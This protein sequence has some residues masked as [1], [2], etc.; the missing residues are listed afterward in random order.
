MQAT[1]LRSIWIKLY[2]ACIT[3]R[4][5]IAIIYYSYRYRDPALVRQKADY[6]LAWWSKRL[7]DVIGL[8]YH[9]E[10]ADQLHFTPGKPYIIMCSHCSFYDIPLS[11]LSIPASM[12]MLTK[13]ELFRVPIWGRGLVAAEFIPIDRRNRRK[14]VRQLVAAKNKMISGIVLWVAPEGTRSLDG[15]LGALK[16]GGFKLAQQVGATIIPLR[17]SGAHEIYSPRRKR[18]KLKQKIAIKIG[19]PIDAVHYKDDEQALM[20]MVEQQLQS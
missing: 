16:K 12:R 7:L 18:F 20:M 19:R 14:A 8:S 17:L 11:F 4:I 6:L 13:E 10:G 9:I 3:I 15:K 1:F 5:S 2:S